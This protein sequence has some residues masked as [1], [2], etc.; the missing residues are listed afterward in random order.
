MNESF[1][2]ELEPATCGAFANAFSGSN[3]L[4]PAFPAFPASSALSTILEDP[5]LRYPYLTGSQGRCIF[6]RERNKDQS[7]ISVSHSTS[8]DKV[9]ATSLRAFLVDGVTSI[10]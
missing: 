2:R 7:L 9:R 10:R 1:F 4:A 3:S 5:N 8:T 6:L